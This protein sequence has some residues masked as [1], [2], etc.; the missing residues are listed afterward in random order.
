LL[1]VD[2]LHR[3]A[4]GVRHKNVAFRKVCVLLIYL[5]LFGNPDLLHAILLLHLLLHKSDHVIWQLRILAFMLS[6]IIRFI[7]I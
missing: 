7:Q 3:M 6:M 5:E 1:T 2:L 4:K